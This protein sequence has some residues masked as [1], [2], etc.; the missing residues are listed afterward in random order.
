MPLKE[1]REGQAFPGVIGQ[2]F[3]VSKP[4]WPA[5]NCAKDGAP[6]MD[7]EYAAPFAFTGTVKKAL[8]DVTGE[9]VDDQAARMRIYLARQ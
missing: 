9:A 8:I 3:D 2:T 5:P 4:A 6:T 7:K 1:Y